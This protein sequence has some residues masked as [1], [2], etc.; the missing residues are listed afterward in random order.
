MTQPREP[1][2]AATAR[3][4]ATPVAVAPAAP[5]PPWFRAVVWDSLLGGLCP[6][7]PIPFLDDLV[8]AR[9]RRRMVER[10]AGRWQVTLTPAQLALLSGGGRGMSVG[11][12]LA[13]VAIYPVKE[14]LRKVLYFLAIKDAVDTFSLLFHQGYLVHAALA[15]GALGRGGPADDA[16]VAATAAAVHGTLGATDTRPLRR[17]LIGVLRNSRDLLRGTVRWLMARL[18]RRRRDAAPAMDVIAD[19]ATA[20]P[21]LG[22]REAEQLLDRLLRALWGERGYLERLEA[23]LARRLWGR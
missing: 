15:H 5:V 12:L 16:R 14:V 8:L 22:S 20:R 6:L 1:A 3:P 4:A 18:G 13:K 21:E 17:L 7:L 11:R 10:L 9:M 23:D 19:E 2:S